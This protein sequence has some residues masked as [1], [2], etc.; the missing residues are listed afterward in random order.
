[1]KPIE[2]KKGLI[3]TEWEKREADRVASKW[4]NRKL[5][6]LQWRHTNK[7]ANTSDNV[8]K[9]AS[10]RPSTVANRFP[11]ARPA[12]VPVTLFLFLFFFSS[13]SV[14]VSVPPGFSFTR[15][16]WVFTEAFDRF[17]LCWFES[18]GLTW[19]SLFLRSDGVFRGF[20]PIL[21]SF[22]GIEFRSL[23]GFNWM[24]QQ[25]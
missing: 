4:R 21:P 14:F 16:G 1:M 23:T 6:T 11:L 7:H 17:R 24:F 9:Q 2:S 12:S 19:F 15:F 22:I 8:R 18:L 13:F 25:F 3:K 5:P 10:R 20:Y